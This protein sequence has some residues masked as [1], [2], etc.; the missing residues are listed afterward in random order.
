MIQLP[1]GNSL[2][3]FQDNTVTDLIKI[4]SE[5]AK[6]NTIHLKSPTGSGKTI[7]LIAYIDKLIEIGNFDNLS[8]IWLSPGNGELEEQSKNKM[9]KVAPHLKTQDLQGALSNGFEENGTTFINWEQVTKKNNKSI[10]DNERK[11]LYEQ[12]AVAH[13]K[14]LNFI[15]IIDEEHS[16]NTSKADEIIQAFASILKIRVSATAKKNKKFTWYEIDE[17]EVILSGLIKRAMYINSDLDQSHISNDIHNEASVLINLADKKR[18]NILAEYKK[19]NKNIRPLVIIQF[20]S[21]SDNLIDMVEIELDKLGYNYKNKLVA[22]WMAKDKVN[23]D[24]IEMLDA[25]PAFLLIKQAIAT[26]WDCPRSQILVKLR[27]N[28]NENF[29]IQTLGRIRRMPE[30]KHYDNDILDSCYLYTFDEKYKE[31]VLQQVES[32]FTVTKLFLKDK[33]KTFSLPKENRDLDFDMVGMK[34]IYNILYQYFKEK[35]KLI[36]NVDRNKQLLSIEGYDMSDNIKGEYRTGKFITIDELKDEKK[37]ETRKLTYN[38]NTKIHGLDLLHSIDTI[39]KTLKMSHENVRLL[40]TNLFSAQSINRN[41]KL[42][43]LN[44]NE[45]YAFIINNSKRIRDDFI[46]LLSGENYQM[47]LIEINPKISTFTIPNEDFFKFDETLHYTKEILSNAYGHYNNSMIV[48]GL[49]SGPEQLFELYC[50]ENKNIDWVYKNGDTGQ[51]YLSIVYLDK[52]NQQ[53]LFY[54][55]YIIK[56]KNGEYWIIET[57]G[58]EKNNKSK[59]IDRK[60]NIKFLAF[61]NYAKKNDIKWGFVR[62]KDNELFI[63]NTIYTEDMNNSNWTPLDENF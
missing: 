22:K 60:S 50:E 39:K 19:I 41:N 10:T 27:E 51:L 28:M 47:R 24:N 7:M 32:S 31:N 45:W 4:T 29:E 20:P 1:Y 21:S 44:K 57:K 40:L 25:E 37:G 12:I 23:L 63:N 55:D 14:G 49:R 59:N 34:D 13:R 43:K 33:V 2:F 5:G 8:F 3:E 61:K 42:L 35:Y 6:N 26:G 18:K 56:L 54:P 52:L 9:E 16:H 58:G 17:K 53:W 15:I 36:D 62:D 11:N 48:D 38:V 30:A 46:E